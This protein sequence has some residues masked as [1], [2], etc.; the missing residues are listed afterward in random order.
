MVNTDICELWDS[1]SDTDTAVG[2][3][4]GKAM[5]SVVAGSMRLLRQSWQHCF[6]QSVALAS[7]LCAA[8]GPS[9]GLS[10]P[11]QLPMLL[12][13]CGRRPPEVVHLLQA[14]HP[15]TR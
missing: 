1:T 13:C 2:V 4:S 3:M 12:L 6:R 10:R 11:S 9:S 5:M 8:G 7:T 15:P 14:T